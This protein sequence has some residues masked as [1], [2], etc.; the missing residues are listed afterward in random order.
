[1][2]QQ[3]IGGNVSEAYLDT[4]NAPRLGLQNGLKV[5]NGNELEIGLGNGLK[6]DGDNLVADAN[7]SSELLQNLKSYLPLTSS[8]SDNVGNQTVNRF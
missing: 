2:T 7:N 5:N 3:V 8:T 1:M 4:G 6:T